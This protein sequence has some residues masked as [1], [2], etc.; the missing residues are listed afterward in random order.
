MGVCGKQRAGDEGT[1]IQ[2]IQ[3]T[4]KVTAFGYDRIA[5]AVVEAVLFE[6]EAETRL[7]IALRQPCG[8]ED[9]SEHRETHAIPRAGSERPCRGVQSMSAPAQSRDLGKQLKDIIR[10][11]RQ[12]ARGS[13][14]VRER[15]VSPQEA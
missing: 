14:I 12:A 8:L 1:D 7:W 11:P 2:V 10:Q 9:Y 5:H 15:V 6:P 3:L 13:A 4:S